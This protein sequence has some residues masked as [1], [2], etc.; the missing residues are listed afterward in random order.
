[1]IF[2]EEKITVHGSDKPDQIGTFSLDTTANPKRLAVVLNANGT[3][4]AGGNLGKLE[5]CPP[6]KRHPSC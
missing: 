6:D 2:K 1:L 5:V 3:R 4:V